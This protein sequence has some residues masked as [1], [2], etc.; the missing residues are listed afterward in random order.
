MVAGAPAAMLMELLI[1][2][3]AA[4][5]RGRVPRL[6]LM[7]KHPAAMATNAPPEPVDA[8]M[9]RVAQRLAALGFTHEAHVP[10][11]RPGAV[12]VRASKTA[13]ARQQAFLDHKFEAVVML[14]PSTAG[15]GTDV[16]ATVSQ[17]DTILIDTGERERLRRLAEYL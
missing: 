7:L 17:I 3:A 13:D 2:V 9:A 10:A 14:S 6:G 1:E 8:A 5:L 11:D 12:V 15:P 16:A 4:L